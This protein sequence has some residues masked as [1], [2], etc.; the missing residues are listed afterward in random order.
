[1]LTNYM[2]FTESSLVLP[3][4]VS[5]HTTVTA[6]AKNDDSV[7]DSIETTMW[8]Q[9]NEVFGCVYH[10]SVQIIAKFAKA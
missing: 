1:M 7:M 5:G 3:G 9:L 2:Y 10:C 4:A 6:S 8:W